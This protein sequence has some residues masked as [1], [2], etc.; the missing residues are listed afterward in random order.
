MGE[1]TDRTGRAAFSNEIRAGLNAHIAKCEQAKP[2][3]IGPRQALGPQERTIPS[4]S[5][6]AAQ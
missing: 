3:T 1:R 5:D 2:T 6:K 4:V